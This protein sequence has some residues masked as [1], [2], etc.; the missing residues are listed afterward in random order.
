MLMEPSEDRHLRDAGGM[1]CPQKR[2]PNVYLC[3]LRITSGRGSLRSLA[4]EA[5]DQ[6]QR[7]FLSRPLTHRPDQHP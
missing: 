4:A 2:A 1:Q 5:A 3:R 6:V 7:D